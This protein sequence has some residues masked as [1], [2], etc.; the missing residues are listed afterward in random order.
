[1]VRR[2]FAVMLGVFLCSLP[3]FGASP[4][5][6]WK[7]AKQGEGI[8]V[9]TRPVEGMDAK[10][11]LGITDVDAPAEVILEVFRDIP[12]FPRWYGFCRE[13]R[14]V[15]DFTAEHKII[16]FVLATQWPTKDRDMVIDVVI[17]E[18]QEKCVISMSA[19]EEELVPQDRK[20][21]RMTHM[22]GRYI[23]TDIGD[24]K[25]H[26]TY[27]VQS[28]PAGYIPAALSNILAKDQ[29]YLTLKGLREMVKDDVYY[30]KSG[31]KRR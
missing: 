31:L 11:F 10:E 15:R 2:I 12:S 4:G 8:E 30:E 23:L 28:D 13:I 29:P 17:D 22:I 18:D 20:Y 16:Y 25:T 19:L 24:G 14:M 3:A 1:M 5:Q 21:I 7:L 27:M 26:V 9:Y 6:E